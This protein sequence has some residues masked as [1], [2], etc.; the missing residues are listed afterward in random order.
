MLNETSVEKL[1]KDADDLASLTLKLVNVTQSDVDDSFPD[2]EFC[3]FR[4]D[5]FIVTIESIIRACFANPNRLKFPGVRYASTIKISTNQ[6]YNSAEKV[7]ELVQN[8]LPN[9]S[10]AFNDKKIDLFDDKLLRKFVDKNK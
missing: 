9:A 6:K 7:I 10:K 2:Y 3:D 1:I 8:S 5:H 4:K